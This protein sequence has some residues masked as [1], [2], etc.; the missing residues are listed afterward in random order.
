VDLAVPELG[1]RLRAGPPKVL[2][3]LKKR[4]WLKDLSRAETG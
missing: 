4:D 3:Q 2:D 1:L